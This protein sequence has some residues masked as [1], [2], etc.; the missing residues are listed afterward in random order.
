MGKD[1]CAEGVERWQAWMRDYI[2]QLL[3]ETYVIRKDMVM[4]A[5]V[6]GRF[7]DLKLSLIPL[8]HLEN[9]FEI[10]LNAQEASCDAG[11]DGYGAD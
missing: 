3:K 11:G 8:P 1:P 4:L 6:S 5:M 9:A 2:L 7:G 10:V